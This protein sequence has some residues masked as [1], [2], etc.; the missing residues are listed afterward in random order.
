MPDDTA[1]TDSPQDSTL[2]S[3]A[4]SLR[5]ALVR[6]WH[7]YDFARDAHAAL[8]DFAVE[9]GRLYETGLTTSDLRW[10]LAK[11]FVQHGDETSVYRDAHRSFAP[12]DGFNFLATTCF[13]LTEKGAVF[14][15]HVMN[16]TPAPGDATS[17]LVPVQIAKHASTLLLPLWDPLRR[18]LSLGDVIVKRFAVPARNQQL[19]LSAFQEEGWPQH[20]DDPLPG[21][22]KGTC[23][24]RLHDAINRLNGKQL[25]PSIRFHG[26]G[27]GNGV[28]WR[29][30]RS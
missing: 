23:K 17:L 19:I 22:D 6:L 28:F 13:V 1:S 12:S 18:Q 30:S 15:S 7:A 20:I 27:H 11:G 29:L 16:A 14:V 9:I 26:N 24:A 21:N 3:I 10:L 8:W 4:D 25:D 5:A 2:L